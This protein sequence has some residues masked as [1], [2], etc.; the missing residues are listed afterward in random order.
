MTIIIKIITLIILSLI[1]IQDYKERAVY[2]IYFPILAVI[3]SFLHLKYNSVSLFL[4]YSLINI[5][6]VL[7]IVGVLY[8]YATYKLKK[9]FLKET[10]GLGDVL[11]MFCLTVAFPTITFLVLIV[12]GFIL[13]LLF[14]SPYLIKNENHTI[15][16]AGQLAGYFGL[17]Y[18][19]SWIFPSINLYLL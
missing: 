12:S 10:F 15:P 8:L 5:I 3:F 2:V 18:S 19:I 17:I 1:F 14:S 9:Q 13:A 6:V 16:L 7:I 11:F 4:N